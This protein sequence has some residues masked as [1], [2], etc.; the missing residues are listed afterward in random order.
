MVVM[1]QVRQDWGLKGTVGITGWQSV[2]RQYLKHD[3]DHA[4]GLPASSKSSQTQEPFE[5][6]KSEASSG[7]VYAVWPEQRN[8][9]MP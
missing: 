6:P 4:E 8:L 1:S 5:D 7:I 2:M 3:Q 9:F